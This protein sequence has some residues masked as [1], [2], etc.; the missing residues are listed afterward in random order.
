MKQKA[1][2]AGG[3]AAVGIVK[4]IHASHYKEVVTDR[5]RVN[6]ALIFQV[7]WSNFYV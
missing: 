5:K 6:P 3:L 4:A 1:Q 2:F 7:Q